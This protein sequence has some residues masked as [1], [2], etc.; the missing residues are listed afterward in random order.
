MQTRHLTSHPLMATVMDTGNDLSPPE[1]GTNTPTKRTQNKPKRKRRAAEPGAIKIKT[2]TKEVADSEAEG[3][4]FE[5]DTQRLTG[6]LAEQKPTSSQVAAAVADDE[7]IPA[8][9]EDGSLKTLDAEEI[10]ALWRYVPKPLLHIGAHVSPSHIQTMS[11]ILRAQ[12]VI[13]IKFADHKMDLLDA[14]AL[15]MSGRRDIRFLRAHRNQK[16]LLLASANAVQQ[17]LDGVFY[18]PGRKPTVK[19]GE[20][21]EKA[22]DQG[23]PPQDEGAQSTSGRPVLYKTKAKSKVSAP[24]KAEPS[25]KPKRSNLRR[26]GRRAGDMEFD[27]SGW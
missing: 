4:S 2:R 20:L 6:L 12:G 15:L 25:K 8:T 7:P 10:E 3:V 1:F 13:K 24:K 18:P 23:R 17:I 14:A 21:E 19:K 9:N 26:S 22:V 5:A 27:D 16:T 11:D